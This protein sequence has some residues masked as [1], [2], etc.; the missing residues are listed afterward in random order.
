MHVMA[1]PVGLRRLALDDLPRERWRNGAGWTRPIASA[2]ADAD[3]QTLWRLSLA[4]VNQASPFSTF[5]GLDRSAVLA[6]GGPVRL[7]RLQG[8]AQ[9]WDLH[10]P[11]DA[12]RFPGEWVLANEAPEQPALIWNVMTRRGGPQ[13]EVMR[14][15]G[16]AWTAVR[17]ALCWAWVLRGSFAFG[18]ADEGGQIDQV[19]QGHLLGQLHAGEGLQVD[20]RGAM[21]TLSPT[22]AD[23]SLLVTVVRVAQA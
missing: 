3:G 4:E 19:D 7:L 12:A 13:A 1:L 14:V 20:A 23:A 22:S 17:G 21:P 9:T 8:G 18:C 2:N 5:A 6:A 11:G 10:A 15:D 16:R